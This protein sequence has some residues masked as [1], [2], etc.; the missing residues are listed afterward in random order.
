MHRNRLA[1]RCRQNGN[2][3][4]SALGTRASPATTSK[5]R[6]PPRPLRHGPRLDAR[7]PAAD[8]S[9]WRLGSRGARTPP[10]VLR[11]KRIPNKRQSSRPSLTGRGRATDRTGTGTLCRNRAGKTCTLWPPTIVL[12]FR[13]KLRKCTCSHIKISNE[14]LCRYRPF[15]L[16][17]IY[18]IIKYI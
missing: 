14:V 11:Q 3:S 13:R 16:R 6:C 1:V 5:L 15:G 8:S 9:R 17:T 10:H 4:P 2:G 7:R 18:Y 12:N